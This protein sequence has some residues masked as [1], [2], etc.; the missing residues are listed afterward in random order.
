MKVLCVDNQCIVK[1]KGD[2]LYYT[3]ILNS[4]KVNIYKFRNWKYSFLSKIP[5]INRLL[6]AEITKLYPEKNGIQLA[7]AKKGIF[8]KRA[9]K[10][11]FKK[12]FHIKR[13]SKP[14]NLCYIPSGSVFFGEYFANIN[15]EEVN[16]YG[17]EDG[18]YHWNVVFTFPKGEINHIH[19]LFYDKY[20]DKIWFCTGDR[21]DECIIGYTEDEFKT[22]VEVFR[23]GQ[24]YRTCNLFFYKDFI[25][26]GTDSQYIVNEIK[27][28]SR[29]S[30]EITILQN[31]QGTAIK[32][33]QVGD[34][35]Y[36]STT[37]EPSEVNKD[38]YSH[39]WISKG[40]LI[41]EEIYKAK[42]DFL[43]SIFQFGSIEFPEYD[44]DGDLETLYFSG[45]A[46]KDIG[47]GTKAINIK[48]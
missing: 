40:G 26:F 46:L 25:V 44:I 27:M 24:E 18:G 10:N 20:T 8:L 11:Y 33:G 36:L 13:G 29:N 42:K 35:S 6:R 23:G 2:T 15:K 17:S 3:K 45:R 41:W 7:I 30:F 31:I 12:V 22:I 47:G 48:K 16:I 19:G 39:L 9:K 4:N 28:F 21:E 37:V 5:I 38:K 43:P 14:L 34:I 32:G 1:S